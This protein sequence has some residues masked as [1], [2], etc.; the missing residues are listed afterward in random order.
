MNAKPPQKH[1]KD[2]RAQKTSEYGTVIEPGTLRL[3]RVL[4][5][6]IERVWA[7]LTVSE[8]RGIWL[9][10]GQMELR[11]G[12]R[13][14]LHWRPEKLSAEK[15]P[16]DKCN[17][18]ECGDTMHGN[19]TRY[20]PPH[21]LSYTWGDKPEISEVTFEL[22]PRGSDVLLV[23]THRRLRDRKRIISVA[24]GWHTHIGILIDLLRSR[25]PRPFW[26]TITALEDE[27][28]KRIAAV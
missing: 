10:S 6:P 2:Q 17:K 20:D 19:I 9:A 3:E 21:V 27:Y 1:E 24:S 11:V 5:G 16:P 8:K 25:E 7:Y 12:G 23:I 22:T 13:V 18:P 26:S 15:T 28:E 4:P 14:E